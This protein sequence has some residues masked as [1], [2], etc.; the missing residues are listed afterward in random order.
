MNR[1]WITHP[2]NPYYS[3]ARFIEMFETL[4]RV[5][6]DVADAVD[7]LKDNLARS[8]DMTWDEAT[9][10][11]RVLAIWP[12]RLKLE[13]VIARPSVVTFQP[14]SLANE[15]T[16]S[17]RAIDAF[18]ARTARGLDDPFDD[19]LP[20]GATSL[21][22]FRDRPLL[23]FNDE[24]IAPIY[25]ELLLDKLTPSIFWWS[26]EPAV[27]Q[28]RHWRADWG[29][30]AEAYAAVVLERIASAT[31]CAF[32]TDVDQPGAW[33]V[34]AALWSRDNRVALFEITAGGLSDAAS[35]SADP[36][37]LREGL[38]RMCVQSENAGKRKA[39]G[40]LQLARDVRLLQEGQLQEKGLPDPI[41][42]HPVL[43]TFDRRFQTPGLWLYLDDE[44]TKA[45]PRELP[46]PL[47]P[48]AVLTIEELEIVEA[49]AVAGQLGGEPPGL[50][51]M[52]RLWEA[53]S[54]KVEAWWVLLKG[55]W[56]S[57]PANTRL[58]AAYDKWESSVRLLLRQTVSIPSET[59]QL[60]KPD[61]RP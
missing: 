44:L 18:L 24:T 45:V 5:R 2:V 16:I 37:H 13:D 61:I 21:I 43:L 53:R 31:D 20:G 58:E 42:V 36:E 8:L 15:L 38:H 34:D 23:R 47:A 9:T 14:Q 60:H 28:R 26:T 59:S 3:I 33:Q 1:F 7:R 50:L 17:S 11:V 32:H 55:L 27:K 10:L 49:L 40:V 22:P 51:K 25:P 54:R 4:P 19:D 35:A 39:E 29:K 48:L 6:P 56:P 57:I 30:V 52:L 41:R 46:W 12:L